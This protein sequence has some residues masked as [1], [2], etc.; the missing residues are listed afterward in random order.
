MR[1]PP[2]KLRLAAAALAVA[3]CHSP[4]PTAPSNHTEAAGETAPLDLVALDAPQVAAPFGLEIVIETQPSGY[5]VHW[6]ALSEEMT[7][8]ISTDRTPR[9]AVE[10]LRTELADERIESMPVSLIL[11][12]RVPW[13]FVAGIVEVA[14][15]THHPQANFAFA[16]NGGGRTWVTIRLGPDGTQLTQRADMAWADA[17]AQIV[18]AARAGQAVELH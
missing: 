13:S 3:A 9:A 11:D 4:S 2:S 8:P 12:R 7:P 16:A 17:H 15:A 14:E 6:N 5:A 10:L 18:A 1:Y